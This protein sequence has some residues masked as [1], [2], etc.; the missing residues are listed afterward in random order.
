MV[1]P[2]DLMWPIFSELLTSKKISGQVLFVIISYIELIC[3]I[4]DKETIKTN[5]IPL[6]FKCFDCKVP[7]IQIL[8]LSKTEYLASLIDFSENKNKIMPRILLLCDDSDQKVKRAALRFIRSKL[9][10]FD[11]TLA[12]GGLLKMIQRNLVS[13]NSASTN[14]M[15]LDILKQISGNFST[16]VYN[17]SNL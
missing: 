11:S 5:I 7:D 12:E 9:G 8:T 10:V 2:R 1:R 16:D 15:L 3:L 17:V 13:G 6:F 4:I 14:M